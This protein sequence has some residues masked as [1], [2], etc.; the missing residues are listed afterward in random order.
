VPSWLPWDVGEAN[1]I[2]KKKEGK[3]S[4]GIF[5][6]QPLSWLEPNKK[7]KSKKKNKGGDLNWGMIRTTEYALLN[8][9]APQGGK[10]EAGKL[11]K[12]EE[13]NQR[14]GS[15]TCVYRKWGMR[16]A[17]NIG[18]KNRAPSPKKLMKVH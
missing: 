3:G 8:N 11:N 9:R 6:K 4:L 7:K 2:G 10:K 16:Q 12:E 14:K 13:A 15:K 1:W 5:K 18:K 17:K